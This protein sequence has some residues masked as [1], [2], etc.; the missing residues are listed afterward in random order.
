MLI[1]NKTVAFLGLALV[2][3]AGL[4]PILQVKIVF[5]WINWNLYQTDTRL[6]LMTYAI[7]ALLGLCF[8]VRQLKAFQL[9]TRVMFV[10]VVVMI[11]AIYFKSNNYFG[12]KIADQLLGKAIHFQ[13][14]AVVFFIGASVLLFS[15]KKQRLKV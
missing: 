15:V 6:F 4:C 2:A 13:W 8:F 12:L 1:L 5:Q 14:G 10:W 3:I 7:I 11:I 9:L